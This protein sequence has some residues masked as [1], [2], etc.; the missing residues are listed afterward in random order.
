MVDNIEI[1]KTT[2]SSITYCIRFTGYEYVSLLNKVTYSD[3]GSDEDK[4]LTL[5]GML[6][7]ILVSQG[8][9]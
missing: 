9:K 8:K 3:Y 4:K 6:K 7:T 5:I 1:L 2:E